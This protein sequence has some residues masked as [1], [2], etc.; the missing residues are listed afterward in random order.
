MTV[1]VV[2]DLLGP[3]G[4]QQPFGIIGAHAKSLSRDMT[5]L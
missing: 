5:T 2:I 1:G 4:Q 3:H